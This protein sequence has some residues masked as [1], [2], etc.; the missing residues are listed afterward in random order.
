MNGKDLL[1][2]DEICAELNA[3]KLFSDALFAF[4]PYHAKRLDR[5]RTPALITKIAP[6]HPDYSER[7]YT[8]RYIDSKA[9]ADHLRIHLLSRD[10]R[11]ACARVLRYDASPRR[12]LSRNGT[13]YDARRASV[14]LWNL[15]CLLYVL[16]N[17]LIAASARAPHEERVIEKFSRRV[18]RVWSAFQQGSTVRVN[19]VTLADDA[20]CRKR[21]W[22]LYQPTFA[23]IHSK[24]TDHYRMA[25]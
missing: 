13:A 11:K 22:R 20:W 8:D 9:R 4:G 25:A 10:I 2:H 16:V 5:R 14:E 12:A 15:H 17:D 6:W 24:P 21:N 18:I 1:T 23:N 3:V 7:L 19:E